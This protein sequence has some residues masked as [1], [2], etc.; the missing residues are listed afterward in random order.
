M[1]W[2]NPIAIFTR[3][4]CCGVLWIACAALI[5]AAAPSTAS[6]ACSAGRGMPRSLLICACVASLLIGSTLVGAVFPSIPAERNILVH[7][8]GGLDWDR[9]VFGKFGAFSGG[10]FGLLPV[11]ARANGYRFEI[12]DEDTI[13]P[14]D[15]SGF[16]TLVLINSPKEWKDD[17]LRA[18]RDFVASR[19]GLLVLGDHT[20]V[21]GLMH[22]FNSLLDG[23]GILF[24]FDSAYHARETWRGCLSTA[25]DAVAS[26][27]DTENPG[28]AIGA[29][30]KLRGWSRPS[31]L[32]NRSCG[33]YARGL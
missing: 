11:Y 15:L 6:L 13:K 19:G 31:G 3:G 32:R 5:D 28:V 22:G 1:N 18:V 16:Q 23:F 2:C 21:F 33:L 4:A 9:P 17:E 30:L 29:S 27:W 8:R 24:Q 10:M 26:A 7:N 12:L 20:D 14:E 25:P